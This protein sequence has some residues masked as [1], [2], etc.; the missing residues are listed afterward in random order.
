MGEFT[1]SLVIEWFTPKTTAV[2]FNNQHANLRCAI[3]LLFIFIFI[4][5]SSLF[6]ILYFIIFYYIL[7]LNNNVTC[8]TYIQA[9]H[10]ILVDTQNLQVEGD[11]MIRV[12]SEAVLDTLTAK[13]LFRFGTLP[14]L[15]C[16]VLFCFVLFCFVLFCFVIFYFLFSIF[17][18]LHVYSA[19]HTAFVTSY[20]L[21]FPRNQL[22]SGAAGSLKDER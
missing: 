12:H 20:V 5:S 9:D 11:I 13:P 10:A 17:Y 19:F 14:P 22:D 8:R 2:I 3:L 18:F 7:F 21:D 4:F 6:F 1:P 15:F 16:F